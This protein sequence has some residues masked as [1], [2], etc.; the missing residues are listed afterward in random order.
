MKIKEDFT[1]ANKPQ[2]NH[3]E[4]NVLEFNISLKPSSKFIRHVA[5]NVK[6]TFQKMKNHESADLWCTVSKVTPKL[7]AK[8]SSSHL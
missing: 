4:T 1:I 7:N 6:S 5:V 2:L 3:S 8:C